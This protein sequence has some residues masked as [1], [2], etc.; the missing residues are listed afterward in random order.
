METET[1]GGVTHEKKE[2]TH[3][4]KSLLMLFDIRVRHFVLEEKETKK[5]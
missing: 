4:H 5:K 1:E 3:T 2:K